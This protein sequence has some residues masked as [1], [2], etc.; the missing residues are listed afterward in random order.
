MKAIGFRPP[1]RFAL[2]L[3]PFVCTWAVS[4]SSTPPGESTSAELVVEAR[5]APPLRHPDPTTPPRRDD[6]D[7]GFREVFVFDDLDE[8]THDGWAAQ[9]LW[10]GVLGGY[11]DVLGDLDGDMVLTGPGAAEVLFLPDVEADTGYGA[12]ISYRW[13]RYE[14]L[15]VYED[16]E[17][18]DSEFGGVR[19]PTEFFYLDLMFRQ[20]YWVESAVQPYVTAGAGWSRAEIANGSTDPGIPATQDA[21]LE[22][23]ITI[24]L[25]AGVAF[26]PLP[27]ISVWGQGLWRF[28]RFESSDGVGGKLESDVDSDA[29]E[30]TAG[31]SL[32]LL[33]R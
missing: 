4:C 25:G 19:F 32:L 30:V 5:P 24:N 9:G 26:Y 18:E 22:D 2:V 20:Y 8:T 7:D 12:Q 21:E 29:W 16:F 1:R 3:V 13:H 15:V 33:P 23:G 6:D 27:W 10:V 31:V 14:L 28:G 17:F 11:S